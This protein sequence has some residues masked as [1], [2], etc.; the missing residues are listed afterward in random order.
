MPTTTPSPAAGGG[1]R[2]E[3]AAATRRAI[4]DAARAL[5][6]TKGFFSTTVDEIAA[7]ARVAPASVYA[8]AGGKQGLL[9]AIVEDRT[10]A[11]DVAETFA[12]IEATDDA[13]ELVRYLVHA[14]RVRFEGA[15]E[16]MR[17]VVDTAP[18]DAGAAEALRVAHASLREGLRR[19]AERLARLGALREGLEVGEATDVL[20]FH[21]GNGAYF[22]LTDDN[23]WSLDRAESWL[24]DAVRGALLR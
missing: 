15:R 8:V 4:H 10:T 18:H 19:T 12:R 3:Y 22:T 5:F 20:W 11:P 21:L 9:K 1:R 13:D 16:L 2:A 17:V 7:A 24:L 6:A 14:T 23:G